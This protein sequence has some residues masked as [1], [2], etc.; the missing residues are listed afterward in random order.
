MTI[1]IA[2]VMGLASMFGR[3]IPLVM[4]GDTDGAM[5]QAVYDTIGFNMWNN[6]FDGA[7]MVANMTPLIAGL[8]IHKFVGGSPLNLNRTLARARVPF[9]RI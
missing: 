3:T 9:I 1:P 4:R 7:K 5:K 8:L 6:S 2:P